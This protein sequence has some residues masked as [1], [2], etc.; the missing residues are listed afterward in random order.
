MTT[1]CAVVVPREPGS[2]GI[3]LA[4]YQGHYCRVGTY[5]PGL[6]R[7]SRSV[8]QAALLSRNFLK[9]VL[10]SS[11]SKLGS[12]TRGSVASP[13]T[14][15]NRRT[16]KGS[17]PLVVLACLT[18]I[19]HR[20][21]AVPGCSPPWQAKEAAPGAL[22]FLFLLLLHALVGLVRLLIVRRS[23][24]RCRSPAARSATGRPAPVASTFLSAP[25]LPRCLVTQEVKYRGNRRSRD[26]L[27]DSS[28]EESL[29]CFPG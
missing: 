22:L 3:G 8:Q 7:C 29:Q 6:P 4:E 24:R 28:P 12:S 21:A 10:Q 14:P 15:S 26:R 11:P 23:V 1:A 20:R 9:E 27:R 16:L 18:F 13:R 17:P 19:S 25:L 5:P 2:N